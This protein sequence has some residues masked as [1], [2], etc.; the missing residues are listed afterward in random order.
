MDNKEFIENEMPEFNL[1]NNHF[2]KYFASS[3]SIGLFIA[4]HAFKYWIISQNQKYQLP[5][6]MSNF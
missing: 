6:Q 1:K 2:N 5:Q 4:L 3:L